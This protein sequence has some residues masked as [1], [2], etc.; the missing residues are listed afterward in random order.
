M[1]NN[2]DYDIV[3]EACI[4]ANPDVDYC[5]RRC[6]A[7]IEYNRKVCKDPHHRR[8]MRLADVLLAMSLKDKKFI[9]SDSSVAMDYKGYFFDPI[10]EE[11]YGVQWNLPGDDLSK[12]SPETLKFLADLL[13]V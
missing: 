12:Q 6:Y 9:L 11:S 7:D 8:P 4:K 2:K 10:S 3:R 5:E 1:R 13:R